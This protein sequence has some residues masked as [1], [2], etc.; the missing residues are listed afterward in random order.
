MKNFLFF[1][2]LILLLSNCQTEKTTV[3]KYPVHVGNLEFDEKIDDPNF[4]RCL[5]EG[6]YAYQYYNGYSLGIEY[7]GEK[8]EIIRT[9]E[10]GNIQSSKDIN[11]YITVRFVVNCEGKAGIF[12]MQQMDEEYRKKELDKKLSEQI[13]SFTKKLNGWIP[14]EIEGRKVDYYQYLT[15]K[16]KH[17][18]VSEI[19]P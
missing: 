7:K 13:L 17:G 8:L 16:I 6:S 11:G 10:K 3:S 5:P 1:L 19:L 15:Y 4:K 18:K 14:K 9:L 2:F 12:R